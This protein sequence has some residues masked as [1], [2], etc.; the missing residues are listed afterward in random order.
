MFNLKQHSIRSIIHII[1]IILYVKS[2][3]RRRDGRLEALLLTDQR[4]L[5]FFTNKDF[6][7]RL[8]ISGLLFLH[9]CDET[10]NEPVGATD[11][12]SFLVVISTSRESISNT[13]IFLF[14]LLV[15]KD[16]IRNR[17]SSIKNILGYFLSEKSIIFS[18]QL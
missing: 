18:M 15:Y 8:E 13:F 14:L 2:Y 4:Q 1:Q 3:S 6:V 9:G 10:R 7:P 5:T 16:F 11:H 17:H 12:S